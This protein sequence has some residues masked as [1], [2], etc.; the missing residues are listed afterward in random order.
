MEAYLAFDA[1]GRVVAWNPAA[2]TMFG[3]TRAQTY[4][5][6]V[7]ELIVSPEARGRPSRAGYAGRRACLGESSGGGCNGRPGTPAATRFPRVSSAVVL[8]AFLK[9]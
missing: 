5:G 8:R 6:P 2:K 1:T 9:V 4:G 3:Y 7:H